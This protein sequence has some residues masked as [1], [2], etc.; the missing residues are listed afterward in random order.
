MSVPTPGLLPGQGAT[1]LGAP[2]TTEVQGRLRPCLGL[3][4]SLSSCLPCAT[5]AISQLWPWHSGPHQ[6][7]GL[8]CSCQPPALTGTWCQ[9]LTSSWQKQQLASNE[10]SCFIFR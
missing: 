6:G 2:F 3:E 4:A 7:L 8:S 10:A 1:Q 9:N 5:L